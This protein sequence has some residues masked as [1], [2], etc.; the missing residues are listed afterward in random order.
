MRLPL[1]ALRILGLQRA[2]F[3]GIPRTSGLLRASG[4]STHP[5][6]RLRI[7]PR[8]FSTLDDAGGAAPDE[9]PDGSKASSQDADTEEAEEVGSVEAAG[10]PEH[11]DVQQEETAELGATPL[12]MPPAPWRH[13]G[14]Y[15]DLELERAGIPSEARGLQSP[16]GD[17]PHPPPSINVLWPHSA[18][19]DHRSRPF[20]LPRSALE[21]DSEGKDAEQQL[22]KNRERLAALWQLSSSHGISWDELDH[23]YVNFAGAGK[24]RY[25]DWSKKDET[26]LPKAALMK[27]SAKAYAVRY[28]SRFCPKNEDGTPRDPAQIWPSRVR[29]LASRKFVEEKRKF[30]GPWAP[31]RLTAKLQQLVAARMIRRETEER[32]LGLRRPKGQA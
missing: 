16:W 7:A 22:E 23:A 30:L 5:A 21:Q 32:A 29:R 10:Q 13:A 18:L 28:L 20:V 12:D 11:D 3:A 27:R 8:R 19:N 15:V 4:Q 25:S 24:K 31:G 1:R 26:S 2:P 9:A 17:D 14:E 6:A